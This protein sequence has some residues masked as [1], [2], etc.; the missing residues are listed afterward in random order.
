MYMRRVIRI[1][2]MISF[3]WK[4]VSFF[5][6]WGVATTGVYMSGFEVIALPFLPVGTLGTAVAILLGFHNNTSYE[7][8]WR[9][10]QCYQEL[11]DAARAFGTGVT[12]LLH[13]P[14]VEDPDPLH[15]VLV[16]RQLALVHAVRN[17]LRDRPASEGL[18]R[19]LEVDEFAALGPS[20]VVSA[21]LVRTQVRALRAAWAA[22]RAS[23]E[24]LAHLTSCVDRFLQA[25]ES[26]RCVKETPLP[27]QFGFVT[28]VFV[29][30]FVLLLPMGFMDLLGWGTVPLSVLISSMFITVEQAGRFTEDPFDGHM[31]DVPIDALSRD[32][33]R[34]LCALLKEEPPP[35]LLPKDDILM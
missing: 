10:R 32:V 22:D 11:C 20:D 14:E 8:W 13:D 12:G 6:I 18:D 7:R 5:A 24:I 33:E 25:A 9:S 19:M 26:C 15:R 23:D 3:A 35:R 29:W 2:V 28:L 16:R 30:V 1:P 17:T 4:N 27:R 21:Q 31:N 34:Q